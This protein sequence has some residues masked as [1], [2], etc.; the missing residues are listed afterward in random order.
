VSCKGS[1]NGSVNIT[2]TSGLAPFTFDWQ[3]AGGGFSATTEDIFGLSVGQYNLKITDS[4][5]CEATETIDITEPGKF[6]MTF[7]LSSSTAGGFNINCAGTSTGSIDVVPVNQVGSPSY[8][9]S[10]GNTSKTRVNIPAGDYSIVITDSNGCTADSSVT[11]TEPD[12][13][14]LV[15]E[16]SQPWCPDKPD[17]EIRLTATGG[18]IGTD[19]TYKWS[20]NST[21]RD[22]TDILSG[23]FK[24][25]VTDLNGCSIKDSVVVKPQRET[26]LIIPNAISPNGDFIN[27]FWNIGLIE[28]YP[29]IEIKIFNRWGEIVWRSE[30]GYPHPW[31]GRSNGSLLPTDS[32]HYIIDLNNGSKPQVGNVT[33]IR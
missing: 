21:G 25:I 10:D 19:Y 3:K 33:V 27:D 22:I 30:K 14:K 28:L 32:Y 15:F 7:T 24:V 11:L 18:V 20:D 4:N 31:D 6:S 17:G 12:S 23:K 29:Q 5:L 8:L 1:T 9:W 26:C 16:I 2:T 13:L